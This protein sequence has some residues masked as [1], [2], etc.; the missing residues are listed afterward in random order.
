[1]LSDQG[2]KSPTHKNCLK[3]AVNTAKTYLAETYGDL[4]PINIKEI[5]TLGI[6]AGASTPERTIKEVME[7]MDELNKKEKE[8]SFEEAFENSMVTLRSGEIVKGRIGLQQY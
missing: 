5:Q 4:P 8:M 3:Y 2:R 7:K 1:M 6:T